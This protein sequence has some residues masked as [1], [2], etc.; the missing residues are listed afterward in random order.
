M[1]HEKRDD[2][3]EQVLLA[4]D[5]IGH[6]VAVILANHAASEVGLEP[7]QHL[8]IA[9]VLHDSEFRQNLNAGSHFGMHTDPD[10]KA[11]FTIDEADNPSCIKLHSQT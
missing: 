9:L 8:R 4:S 6:P 1:L 5:P 3:L 7:M 10:V 2:R 11:A